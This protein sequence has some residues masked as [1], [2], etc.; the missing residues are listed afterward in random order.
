M[1]QLDVDDGAARVPERGVRRVPGQTGERLGPDELRSPSPSGRRDLG[2]VGAEGAGEIRALYAAMP[3][4]T[5]SRM[6]RPARPATSVDLDDLLGAFVGDLALGDLLEGDRQRLVAQ[7]VSTR[8]GTNSPR[9]R[10]AGC[11]TS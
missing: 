7:T 9:P 10:R 11:S 4:Q 2:A 3:P 5:P 1:R 6:R 8:G